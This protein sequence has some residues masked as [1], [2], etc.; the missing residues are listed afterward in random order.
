M[1]SG[2]KQFLAELLKETALAQENLAAIHLKPASVRSEIYKAAKAGQSSLRIRLPDGLDVSGTDAGVTLQ[3]WAD[4]NGL[5]MVW[6]RRLC[7]MP[8][9][10]RIDIVEPLISWEPPDRN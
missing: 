10:R 6:E 7:D 2:M 9:G 3:E 8:D 4:Q 1:K 5:R